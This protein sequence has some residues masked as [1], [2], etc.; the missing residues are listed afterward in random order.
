MLV[1]VVAQPEV[2]ERKGHVTEGN[3]V[4]AGV[5]GARVWRPPRR[6]DGG[7]DKEKDE[8]DFDGC[9]DEN[10]AD[11][12]D[13]RA[14][15]LCKVA[16]VERRPVWGREPALG[17]CCALGGARVGLKGAELERP[18]GNDGKVGQGTPL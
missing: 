2:V 14:G 5:V 6:L 13:K 18:E 15:H 3:K 7:N 10:V 9:S 12:V 1:Q 4:D 16:L 8:G 17:V 11:L